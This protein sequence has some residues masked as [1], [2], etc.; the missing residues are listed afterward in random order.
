[1]SQFDKNIDYE[2]LLIKEKAKKRKFQTKRKLRIAQTKKK[3]L[4]KSL[5]KNE[6]KATSSRR[7]R[8]DYF[9]NETNELALKRQHLVRFIRST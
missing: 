3:F 5:Y 2:K 8:E 7:S 4:S 9:D 1:M 6:I